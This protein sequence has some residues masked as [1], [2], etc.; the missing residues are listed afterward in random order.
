[1]MHEKEIL[2]VEDS[3]LFQRPVQR[4]LQ[5]AGYKVT[6]ATSLEEALDR[7]ARWRFHL[8]IIDIRL[9]EDDTSN[10]EGLLLLEQIARRGLADVLPC[11][12]LSG[13][14][15][16][17]HVILAMKQ[18]VAAVLEKEPGYLSELMA[19]VDEIFRE[20][21]RTNFDL[22][23]DGPSAGWLAPMAENVRWE[24][25]VKPASDLLISS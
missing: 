2:L 14:A 1:M 12:I 17:R 22:I 21:V 11:I 8:A 3:E 10:E 7:L 24:A 6:L 16:K 20:E 5:E 25:K 23:Y 4:W 13:H 15:L 9:H 18:R 19:T